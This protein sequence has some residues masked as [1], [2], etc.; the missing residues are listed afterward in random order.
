M[1]AAEMTACQYK[2]VVTIG[3]GTLSAELVPFPLTRLSP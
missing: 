2:T 3:P 1:G